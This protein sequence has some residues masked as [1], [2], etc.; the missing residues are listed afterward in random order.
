MSTKVEMAI[1]RM[2]D[3]RPS[4]GRACVGGREKVERQWM[5][6]EARGREVRDQLL[7]LDQCRERGAS[8]GG[9][10]MLDEHVIRV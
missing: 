2:K 6:E 7:E 10:S 8:L 9:V 1:I 5:G 3:E 4:K